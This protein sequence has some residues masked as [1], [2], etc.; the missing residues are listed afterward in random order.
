MGK[1][2]SKKDNTSSLKSHKAGGEKGGMLPKRRSQ[3]IFFQ[4]G[5]GHVHLPR[6]SCLLLKAESQV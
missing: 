3:L 2:A 4:G 6:G 1:R 5:V